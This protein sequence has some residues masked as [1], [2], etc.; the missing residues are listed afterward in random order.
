MAMNK[1]EAAELNSLRWQVDH[2]RAKVESPEVAGFPLS[3]DTTL[4]R[5]GEHR[6]IWWRISNHGRRDDNHGKGT[7]CYYV[8]V[9]EHCLD[10]ELF[11][12]FWLPATRTMERSAG[13]S[14]PSYD[15]WGPRWSDAEWHGGVTWYKKHG[16]LDGDVRSVEVGCDYNHSWDRDMGYP[17][18]FES[19][20]RDCHRTI[21]ALHVLYPFKSRCS[22]TGERLPPG[23]MVEFEGRLYSPNGL[24][25]MQSQK[26][27]WEASA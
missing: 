7:W 5:K 24:E 8:F 20:L 14:T 17:F 23:E 19:V 18:D 11:A 15:Y 3:G 21:D 10:P 26:K 16:G 27:E 22:W 9:T 12:E 6:N 25:K 13:Y 4:I 2:L 1:K